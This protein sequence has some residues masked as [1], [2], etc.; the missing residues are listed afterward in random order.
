MDIILE[1]IGII[2]LATI[3]GKSKLANKRFNFVKEKSAFKDSSCTYFNI[4][5]TGNALIKAQSEK[6]RSRK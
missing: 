1:R 5:G 3:M 6:Y 2:K 4:I